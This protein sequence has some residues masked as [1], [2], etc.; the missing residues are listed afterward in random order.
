MLCAYVCH[1]CFA[2]LTCGAYKMQHSQNLDES[3]EPFKV[4]DFKVADLL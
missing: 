2:L 4:C 1:I 3:E